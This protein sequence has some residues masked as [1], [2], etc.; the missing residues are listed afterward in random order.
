MKK[1]ARLEHEQDAC[2]WTRML[3][4]FLENKAPYFETMGVG[5]WKEWGRFSES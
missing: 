1:I 4:A 3:S 2:L 5:F